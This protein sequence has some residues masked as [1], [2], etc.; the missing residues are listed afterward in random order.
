MKTKIVVYFC[1]LLAFV[2]ATMNFD[3]CRVVYLFNCNFESYIQVDAISYV[4]IDE[5]LPIITRIISRVQ[6]DGIYLNGKFHEDISQFLRKYG[7]AASSK[8]RGPVRWS[9]GQVGTV[10]RGQCFKRTIF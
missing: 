3:V 8:F 6:Q 4:D 10:L 5:Q 7:N 1:A 2:S 9:S